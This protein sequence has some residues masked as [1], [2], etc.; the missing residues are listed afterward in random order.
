MPKETINDPRNPGRVVEVRWA[1]D[2]DVKV[3]TV[4][5]GKEAD[6]E[7]RG[8]YADLDRLG[9]NNLIR[10]LRRARDAAYGA[11]A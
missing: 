7:G 1:R 2:V 6:D 11:D 4:D 10:V 3:G 5:P 9:I 8:L